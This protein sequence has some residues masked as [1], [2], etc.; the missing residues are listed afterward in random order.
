MGTRD[1]YH[2]TLVR[3]C[4]L[5]GDETVLARALRVPVPALVDWLLGQQP[6]PDE[7]FLKAV[8][9]VLVHQQEHVRA[10][11]DLLDQIRRRHPR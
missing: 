7:V 2:R 4:A 6:V 5:A 11:H 8:D 1:T 3:A 9:Y 10:V